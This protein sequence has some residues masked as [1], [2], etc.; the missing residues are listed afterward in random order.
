MPL[1]DNVAFSD[2]I[3]SISSH[4]KRSPEFLVAAWGMEKGTSHVSV[5][6]LFDWSAENHVM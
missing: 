2:L 1:T 5:V 6:G 4:C 3:G